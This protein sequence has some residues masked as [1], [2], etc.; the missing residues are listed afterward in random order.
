MQRSPRL[1][2]ETTRGLLASRV[3]QQ[4]QA[5]VYSLNRELQDAFID[6]NLRYVDL[7]LHGGTGN[8]PRAALRR[9]R[10]RTRGESA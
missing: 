9:A 10:A 4:M 3:T 5:L 7:I 1:E 2:L 6:A 8:V